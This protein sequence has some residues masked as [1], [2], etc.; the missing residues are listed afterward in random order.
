MELTRF[1]LIEAVVAADSLRNRG[2]VQVVFSEPVLS[3]DQ[4]LGVLRGVLASVYSV[5]S[6]QILCGLFFI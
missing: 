2:S 5:L 4:R 3:E 6:L 1:N